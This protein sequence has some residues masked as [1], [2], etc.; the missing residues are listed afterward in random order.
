MEQF[1]T[2]LKLEKYI[3]TFKQ[4]GLDNME[5]ILGLDDSQFNECMTECKVLIG[6]K[7]C[8]KNAL[9]AAHCCKNT[10]FAKLYSTQS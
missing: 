8:I 6:H 10:I 7:M 5:V 1:L 3:D 9:T 4:N 2:S